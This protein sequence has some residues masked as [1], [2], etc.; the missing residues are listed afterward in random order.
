MVLELAR[1]IKIYFEK[2]Y[3]VSTGNL[4]D[5]KGLVWSASY[6]KVM[7]DAHHGNIQVRSAQVREALL[8]CI[9]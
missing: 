3:R 2:F 1:K 7:V 5:V 4:H 9:F 6:V 8:Y